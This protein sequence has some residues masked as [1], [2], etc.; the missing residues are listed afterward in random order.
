MEESRAG[1]SAL[2]TLTGRPTQV[3]HQGLV[4]EQADQMSGLFALSDADLW[5]GY[6]DASSNTSAHPLNPG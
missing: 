6:E 1:R 2:T 5:D 4:P 3:D